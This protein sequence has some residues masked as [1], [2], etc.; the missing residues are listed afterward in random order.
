MRQFLKFDFNY[1]QTLNDLVGVGKFL[2]YGL[3][4]SKTIDQYYWFSTW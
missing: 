1:L 2:K 3:D 4:I